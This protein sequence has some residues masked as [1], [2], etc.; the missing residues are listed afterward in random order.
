MGTRKTS[1]WLRWLRRLAII[2]VV[3]FV[4][5]WAWLGMERRRIQANYDAAIARLDNEEPGW[6]LEEMET[7]RAE[8]PDAE[9]SALVVLKAYDLLPPD[10][11][12]S[13][14]HNQGFFPALVENGRLSANT[15]GQLCNQLSEW[16]PV[17]AE[18]RKL[19]DLPRGRYRLRIAKPDPTTTS[20]IDEQKCRVI[21]FLLKAD[22]WRLCDEGNLEGALSNC[23]AI[24][25]AGRPI[26]E[27]PTAISQLI[28]STGGYVACQIAERA[29]ALGEPRPE[30]LA[31]VQRWFEDEDAFPRCWQAMRSRRAEWH[32]IY[33]G[34]ENGSIPL[35]RGSLIGTQGPVERL[36]EELRDPKEQALAAHPHMLE[37]TTR[38]TKAAKLPAEKQ[39]AALEQFRKETDGLSRDAIL[40]LPTEERIALVSVLSAPDLLHKLERCSA[41]LRSTITC[42]ALERYRQKHGHWPEELAELVPEQLAA[43]PVDPF[44]GQP[45]HYVKLSDGVFVYSRYLSGID[46]TITERTELEK[47]QCGC[48][49]WNRDRR[50]LKPAQE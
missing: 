12:M 9:N 6:R 11:A 13:E 37:L 27:E 18:C 32:Q 50:G 40:A 1:W 19:K 49:L 30:T 5:G 28:R 45:L 43:V 48:R 34:W 35:G 8:V 16:E 4:A 17:V 36:L 46:E 39:P 7:A 41:R 22:A 23:S 42:L 10:Y 21:Y 33:T 14:L 44:D 25:N 38:L 29:M 15:Y 47:K 2:P 26:G 20:L 24:L 31:A 3:I